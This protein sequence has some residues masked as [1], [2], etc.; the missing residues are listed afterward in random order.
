MK[1]FKHNV[2]WQVSLSNGETFF[3][4][5]GNYQ[6][7]PHEK[8]PWQRLIKYIAENKLKITSIALYTDLGQSFNLPSSGKNPKFKAF[9]DAEKPIDYNMFRSLAREAHVVN[10]KAEKA[11]ISDWFTTIEAIYSNYKLQLW[12]DEQ[13]TKNC[14]V[15]VVNI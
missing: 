12:V 8:S 5:K 15:L 9:L 1:D 14:W 4:G 7:I 2:K 11:K 10:M 6:E 3:E 13:N